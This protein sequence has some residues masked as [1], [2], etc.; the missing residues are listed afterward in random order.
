MSDPILHE[1][2]KYMLENGVYPCMC[3][4]KR[5]CFYKKQVDKIECCGYPDVTEP[6][7]V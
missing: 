7:T 3:P 4:S 2:L 5:D 6:S 1:A